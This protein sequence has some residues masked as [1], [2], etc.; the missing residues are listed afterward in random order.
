MLADAPTSRKFRG[1]GLG[2]AISRRLAKG[3]RKAKRLL[4][5]PDL[6]GRRALVVDDEASRIAKARPFSSLMPGLDSLE[7]CCRLRGL[8]HETIVF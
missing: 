1:T 4:P 7:F 8:R 3:A 2:L 6:R 5:H